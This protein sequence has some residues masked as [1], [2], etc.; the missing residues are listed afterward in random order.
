M[1]IDK[2]MLADIKKNLQKLLDN[3]YKDNVDSLKKLV[4]RQLQIDESLK[5]LRHQSIHMTI[6]SDEYNENQLT[7][8]ELYEEKHQIELKLSQ[9]NQSDKIFEITFNTILD[10]SSRASELFQ[11]S[12]IGRKRKIL[13]LL[14]P[15]LSLSGEN[16]HYSLRKPFNEVLEN[17]ENLVWLPLGTTLRTESYGDVMQYGQK[18][19]LMKVDLR[20]LQLVA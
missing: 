4:S 14:F 13:S 5:A 2:E 6:G 8:K 11:S 10:I 18:L 19:K 17:K 20:E 15:N 9:L 3:H 7:R 12:E 16:L 1:T